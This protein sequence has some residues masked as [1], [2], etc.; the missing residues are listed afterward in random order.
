[1]GKNQFSIEILIKNPQIIVK[2]YKIFFIY[3]PNAQ[4]F[5]ES[6]LSFR[7]SMEMILQILII[8]NFSTNFSRFSPKFSKIF[9]Q[10][11]IVLLYL[12]H[13]LAFLVNLKNWILEFIG[14]FSEFKDSSRKLEI[15]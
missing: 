10:F 8:L 7:W 11:P 12:S 2:I 9:I 15:L 3:S 14:N 13:F 6:F 4:C 1:M 5:A